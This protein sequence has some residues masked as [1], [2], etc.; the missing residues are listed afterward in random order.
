MDLTIDLGDST[1]EI[2]RIKIREMETFSKME[3]KILDL[4]ET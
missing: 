4:L 2:D 1:R 3:G